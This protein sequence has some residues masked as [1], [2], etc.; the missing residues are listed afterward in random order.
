MNVRN[1]P[2]N[3]LSD[4]LLVILSLITFV[5]MRLILCDDLLSPAMW[6]ATG[7]QAV[8]ALLL[9]TLSQSF[10]VISQRTLLPAFFYL[11]F[12]STSPKYFEAWQG[13]LMALLV[14]L[15]FYALFATYQRPKS[16]VNALNIAILLTLGSF[17]WTP[18]LYFFALFWYGLYRFKS[19]NMKTFFATW[20]G[21]LVIYFFIA[22]WSLFQD[23]WTIFQSY[24]P[25][26]DT[27]W[28][29]N[30]DVFSIK[31][32]LVIAYLGFLFL[33][34][35]GDIFMSAVSEKV[36]T[37]TTL[38]YLYFFTLA[39]FIFFGMQIQTDYAWRLIIYI[40]IALLIAHYF[41]LSDNKNSGWLFALTIAVFVVALI[42]DYVPLNDLLDRSQTGFK[43][44]FENY[45][46]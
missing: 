13:S 4:R 25:S 29:W 28:E 1:I 22:T 42:D 35:G 16:Q 32:W 23:D 20:M 34:V 10:L 3:F 17:V 44:L 31:E 27:Q 15:G 33:R 24:V 2:K 8:V 39:V 40:P 36:R 9:L 41:T 7:I 18:M 5:A 12:A 30:L 37:A 14:L 46:N 26:F 21:V 11:L 19:L 45:F 43:T 38:S 6:A